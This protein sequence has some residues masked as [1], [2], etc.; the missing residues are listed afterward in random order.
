MQ[1]AAAEFKRATEIDPQYAQAHA[2]LAY[3]YALIAVYL[4]TDDPVWL[5]LTREETRRAEMLDPNLAE[6]HLA[7]YEIL[8]SVYENFQIDEAVRELRL[9]ERFDPSVG[10]IQLAHLYGHLGLEEPASRALQRAMEIDPTSEVNHGRY[11][12]VQTF[13]GKYDEAIAASRRFFPAARKQALRGHTSGRTDWMTP[14]GR[15]RLTRRALR[16]RTT[17]SPSGRCF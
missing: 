15:L 5:G 3:C 13:L 1:A 11:V 16:T 8:F 6:V 10:H 12:N 4:E 14:S 2:Q 17:C 9:A 7:R